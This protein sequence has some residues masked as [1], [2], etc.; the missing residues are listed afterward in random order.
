MEHFILHLHWPHFERSVA[1]C[2]RQRPYPAMSVEDRLSLLEA[3]RGRKKGDTM[4]RGTGASPGCQFLV[5]DPAAF[6]WVLI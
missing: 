6:T 3:G 2:G 5:F 4:G 1:T